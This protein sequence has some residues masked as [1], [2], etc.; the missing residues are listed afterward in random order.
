SRGSAERPDLDDLA[1]Q[2]LERRVQ[3]RMVQGL[4]APRLALLPRGVARLRGGG[5]ARLGQLELDPDRAAEEAFADRIQVGT[6]AEQ[7]LRAD[8]GR[9]REPQPFSVPVRHTPAFEG[10]EEPAVLALRKDAQPVE[11]GAERLAGPGLPAPGG[12]G[13]GGGG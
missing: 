8:A 13:R 9:D 11:D 7:P 3:R 5:L 10:C 6:A 2:D 1:V 12:R 4:P